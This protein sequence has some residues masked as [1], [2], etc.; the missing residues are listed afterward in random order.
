MRYWYLMVALPQSFLPS[1]RRGAS[2]YSAMI[3]IGLSCLMFASDWLHAEPVAVTTLEP[4]PLTTGSPW[5][6]DLENS[7]AAT[8]TKPETAQRPEHDSFDQQH[9]AGT[10]PNAPAATPGAQDHAA[11]QREFSS[12][13]KEA[14]RPA[15]QDIADSGF[16]EAIRSIESDLGLS[17]TRP[18]GAE[19]GV[20]A[21][22]SR[23]EPHRESAGW[24]TPGNNAATSR[25]RSAEEIERDQIM[26]KVMLKELIEEVKPWLFA[27]VGLYAL[28]YSVKLLL[29]YRR[30]K[31][32]RRRKRTSAS[33]RRR[34]RSHTGHTGHTGHH[35][36]SPTLES[37]PAAAR[38]TSA[39]VAKN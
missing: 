27:L 26:A 33:Q 13:I 36:I 19:S 12:V 35:S 1:P 16:V 6:T 17:N 7:Q 21:E 20:D 38:P 31:M 28:G 9:N 39:S 34:H 24:A 8:A 30:W 18:F 22:H 4:A 29:D 15:Y 25:P 11:W 5:P 37:D 2:R 14:V 3:T 10:A 23:S 32:A